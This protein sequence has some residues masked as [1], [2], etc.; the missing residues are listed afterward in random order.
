MAGVALF[1]VENKSSFCD[2]LL[3][4]TFAETGEGRDSFGEF[5]MS[6][7]LLGKFSTVLKGLLNG[8]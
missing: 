6:D 1:G 5:I 7:L 3:S 2:E 4:T 8:R